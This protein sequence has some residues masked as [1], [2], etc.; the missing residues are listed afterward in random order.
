MTQKIYPV[1]PDFVTTAN[2][3]TEHYKKTYQRSIASPEDTDAFWASR[4]ELIDWIKKPT[5]ISNVNYDL[6]DFRINWFEDGELN[7]SINCLDRHLATNPYKPAII[8]EG[9]HP[10]LHKIISFK[11]L[12]SEVCRLGNAMRKLGVQKGDRVS[13]YMPMIPEAV[14]GMLACARIGA[15]HS[16]VFAVV[17]K[18][19][20]TGYIF[21]VMILSFF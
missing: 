8:W 5:I 18:S 15:V 3:T 20:L 14:V 1:N 13:L 12:H 2:T 21:W 7:I 6:D 9:D 16:V 17:T 11:E 4:A 19:G 10:S